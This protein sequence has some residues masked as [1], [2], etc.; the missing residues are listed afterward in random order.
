MSKRVANILMSAKLLILDPKAWTQGAT[1]RLP[2]GEI[3]DA[4]NARAVCFCSLGAI[5]HVTDLRLNA[6]NA[7]ET[8]KR[9]GDA[10]NALWRA[11]SPLGELSII[12]FNDS[13]D[14]THADVLAAFDLAIEAER[15]TP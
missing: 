14:R 4:T 7:P 15:A 10:A 6:D 8:V 9:H 1:A 13:P 5:A 3:V 11:I 2:D 12:G